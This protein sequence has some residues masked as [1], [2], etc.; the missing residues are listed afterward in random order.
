MKHSKLVVYLLLFLLLLW[1]IFIFF[2]STRSYEQQTI[3]PLLMKIVNSIGLENNLPDITV[4]FGEH[5]ASLKNNP[6]GFVELIFRK[7]A[8]AFVYGTLAIFLFLAITLLKKCSLVKRYIL[9]MISLICI[10]SAD[11]FLQNYSIGRNPS[12]NDIFLDV[13]GG[14]SFLLLFFVV[15]NRF[16]R[17]QNNKY[18]RAIIH[19]KR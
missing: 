5:R 17:K 3:K 13:L 11:E 15:T 9:T 10:A 4:M 7:S 6:Y 1:I 18:W 8:H 16:R 12:I 2:M 19:E 14:N